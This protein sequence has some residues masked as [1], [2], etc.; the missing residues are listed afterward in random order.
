[1]PME[2]EPSYIDHEMGEL[3]IDST[4]GSV[5]GCDTS[6]VSG[7][8]VQLVG[9]L[10]CLSPGSLVNFTGSDTHLSGSVQPYLAPAAAAALHKATAAAHDYI[11]INSAYRS[12]AQQYLLYKWWK[13]GQ[14]DIQV[15]ATPGTS[16]HQSGRAIDVP[17]Y[18]YWKP[19]L[20]GEGWKWFGTSDLVH[21]DYLS[22]PDFSSESVRAF[23]RL[24]NKNNPGDKI[25]EDGSWGPATET[26]M[27]RSPAGG[28]AKTGC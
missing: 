18:S 7:L 8:T 20:S 6:I 23:Q 9:T 27:V 15:A 3:H 26:R 17:S 14:C 21:F 2:Y 28:F 11:T 24:W 13:A 25:A 5:G 22:A 12:V 4:V 16:N 1:M 19:Y 10:N